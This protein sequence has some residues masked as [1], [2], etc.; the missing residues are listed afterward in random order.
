MTRGP[1]RVDNSARRATP[2]KAT[3]RRALAGF[4]LAPAGQVHQMAEQSRQASEKI[5]ALEERMAKLRADADTWKQRHDD[6]AAK[7]VEVKGA[8]AR[9]EADAEQARAGVEHAKARVNEWKGRA[10]SETDEK[11]A[12][13]A[14]LEEAQRAAINAREYLM[15]TEAKLDLIEAAIQVL[16]TRTR[17]AAL[18]RL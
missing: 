11:L 18:N 7:L 13:R 16:D 17:D 2:M 15:A 12:L 1:A 9:A 10:E 4:G 8:A 3:I 5:T 14:R 6:L